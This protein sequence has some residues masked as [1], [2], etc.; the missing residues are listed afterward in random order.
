MPRAALA[1]CFSLLACSREPAPPPG[2]VASS[3]PPAPPTPA[4]AAPLLELRLEGSAAFVTPAEIA[5]C[6]SERGEGSA[7][8]RCTLTPS[9]K[10]KLAE[11]TGANVGKVMEMVVEG[12]VRMRPKIEQAITGGQLTLWMGDDAKA[13]AD[14]ERFAAALSRR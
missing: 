3:R 7:L 8:L 14:A 2:P 12:K 10:D 6:A 4:P 9:G 1:L 13:V 11:V 5:R